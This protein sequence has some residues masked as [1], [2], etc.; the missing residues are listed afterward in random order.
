LKAR[1]DPSV[2]RQRLH[3]LLEE[4]PTVI[5]FFSG[6]GP[7]VNG[8]FVVLRRRCG[9]ATCRCSRG[10]EHR[11]QVFLDR[12]T[13]KRK[14]FKADRQLRW[15]LRKPSAECRRLRSLRAH[16]QK[17]NREILS[18]CDRLREHRLQEGRRLM[19]RLTR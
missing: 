6:Y 8:R 2:D 18:A 5:D 19:V 10:E 9:K 1:Y 11:S 16:L 12:S 7:L 17:L 4:L 14:I 15:R 3:L 13:G